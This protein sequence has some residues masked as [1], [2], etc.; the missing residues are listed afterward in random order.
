MKKLRK[1]HD[2]FDTVE[3]FN[4]LCQAD[5]ELQSFKSI[6]VC[7][8]RIYTHTFGPQLKITCLEIFEHFYYIP[9]EMLIFLLRKHS[10]RYKR[11][12]TGLSES[13]SELGFTLK[14][15]ELVSYFEYV[16]ETH[17]Y[18]LVLLVQSTFGTRLHYEWSMSSSVI[19]LVSVN[20]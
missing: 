11:A 17:E 20:I 6:E 18:F 13:L 9:V 2:H 7:H 15:R 1:K 19:P 14:C 12:K 4:S 8:A 3:N 16:F 5:S 10:F